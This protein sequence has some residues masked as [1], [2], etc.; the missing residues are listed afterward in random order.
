MKV[1]VTGTTGMV[2]KGVLLECLDHPEVAEV[3]VVNR[4][5]IGMNHPKLKE[6]IHKDFYDLSSIKDRL[7]GY[8]ACYFCLGVSV[9]GLSEQEY[10]RITY[11]L[12]MHFAQTV[13]NP[14]MTFIYVSGTGTDSTE[15][16]KTMWARI[17]GRTENALLRMPFRKAYMFRPGIILPVKGVRSK[18]GWYNAIY[19]IMRPF[20]PLLRRSGS[21]TDTEKVGLAMINITLHDSDKLHLENKDINELATIH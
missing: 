1:I 7:Q 5:S 13:I 14:G 15:D 10:T 12:T 3:L 11:D 18:T 21:V 8:D 6:L 9:I 4:S 20:F 16:G 17:K 2:G 19:N